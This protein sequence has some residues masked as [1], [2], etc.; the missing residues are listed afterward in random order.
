MALVHLIYQVRW[1][2]CKNE[3]D[4]NYIKDK[5]AARGVPSPVGRRLG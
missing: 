2:D 1:G 5:I 4:R 3:K